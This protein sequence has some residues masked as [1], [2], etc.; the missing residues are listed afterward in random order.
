[1]KKIY[2][3]LGLLCMAGTLF[4]QSRKISGQVVSQDDNETL[5]GVSILTK[6]S[7]K[8]TSTDAHG[9]FLLSV[10][11][12][13]TV[14]VVS[15]VGYKT[16]EV[17][18]GSRAN[19]VVKLISDAKL[20]E[21]IVVV[22]YGQ[23]KKSDLTGAVS[24][25]SSKDIKALPIASIE[26]AMQGRLPG[27][28]VQTSS[29]QPG[30]G[31]SIRIRGA[32]SIAGGNEPLFVIDGVPQFNS[33]LSS[34]STNG[35]AAINPSDVESIEVLKDASATAIYG[36]RAA[37]GV[38]MVTTKMGKS[39][40]SRI[41]FDSYVG[42]QNISKKLDLMSGD[43]YIAYV[44]QVYQNSGQPIPSVLT[45]VPHTNTDWQSLAFR[46]AYTQSHSLSF[47]GGSEKTQYYTSINYLNQDGIAQSSNFTKGSFR[48]NLNS[49]L[50]D[51][52]SIHT[53]VFG[54]KST[55]NGFSPADGTPTEQLGKSGI[56]S[57]LLST[58][59]AAVYNADGTYASPRIYSFSGI[60]MEN[61]V[62]YIKSSL[63]QTNITHVQA[64][65]D[66][67]VK[68]L[69]GLN[70]T[71]RFAGVTEDFRRDVYLPKTLVAVT[72][73]VG[74]GNLNQM[75]SLDML[76][77]DFM[78]Y[79]V[80]LAPR[81]QFDGLLGTSYQT[82]TNKTLSM[83]GTGY[84]SDDLKDYNF[85]SA[86]NVT[87]P[88][89][90]IITN[91]IASVFGRANFTY[92]D[93]YLLTVTLREDGASVFGADKKYGLFPSAAIG[94][95]VAEESFIKDNYKWLTSL[96]LR[97]S[98]G[99]TGNPA[100]QPYQSLSLGNVVNTSQGGGTSLV[101]GLAPTLPNP[102]LSWETTAQTNI[103][104]DIGID[105]DRYR[106]AIDFYNKDT[107]NLLA[108]VQL[109]PSSGYTST[110]DNVG[111]VRNRGIELSAGATIV[112]NKGI[113]WDLDGNIAINHNTVLET[114]NNLDVTLLYGGIV[115]VGEPLGSFYT[116]HFTGFDA[117]GKQTYLDR[118]NSGTVDAADNMVVGSA[119]PTFIYGLTSNLSYKKFTLTA[120]FQGVKGARV[121]N[122]FLYNLTSNGIPYNHLRNTYDYNPQPT[123]S[124]VDRTSDLY[125]QD[126]SYFR[127]KNI[128]LNYT[129]PLTGKSFIKAMNFYV[130]GTNVF[131][132]TPYSGYDPEV[133]SFG[134]SN[135]AQG[136]DYGAY[137]SAKT[138]TLG[139]SATF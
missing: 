35:L 38:V 81:L 122:L 5:I 119:Y 114:K 135:S 90:D 80:K 28:Q 47:N 77:E 17:V 97:A 50:N 44:A 73:G 56:G 16:Q 123:L 40:Q 92:L 91:V 23:V 133:N 49:E 130:S 120:T 11:D 26:S 101:V 107:K 34:S 109:P 78:D 59:S 74:L 46:K 43:E 103:G 82:K 99:L 98:Y 126:A 67:K 65:M 12:N 60:D 132:I 125:I 25:I 85:Q 111:R 39:G 13:N 75:N 53:N 89:T 72:S 129:L 21:Q 31:I 113:R 2:M 127:L 137:P 32:S 51:R 93:K 36:S 116:L 45:T 62:N 48:L 57:V 27:V 83:Q 76:A 115:R 138:Y 66:L 117:N 95:R 37:N 112:N 84:L 52:V 64:G 14:L 33:A 70:N 88:L 7:A 41:I 22:G 110:I 100:I 102:N 94:W 58:P 69:K 4:A 42:E 55:L 54:T 19:L 9:N 136:V 3:L 1:M 18:V 131:T 20:L 139:L 24:S 124:S 63:D 118:N 10:P 121:N 134:G 15:Y 61:P 128:R 86:G 79:S 30:S 8:G 96:K 6:G 106:A 105:N 68:I 108:T 71:I 29:G 87:K 104:L